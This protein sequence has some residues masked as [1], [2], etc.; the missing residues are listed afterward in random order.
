M[1]TEGEGYIAASMHCPPL[2]FAVAESFNQ[3]LGVGESMTAT[4]RE[5]IESVI[6]DRNEQATAN[7]E[8][9][10]EEKQMELIL[11]ANSCRDYESLAEE[12]QALSERKQTI[13][14][15]EAESQ[16]EKERIAEM[17]KLYS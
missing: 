11:Y 5:N 3:V 17:V 16:G 15:D 10:M 8:K 1:K 14:T 4:L 9:E 13:L 6:C 7:I 12:I 2:P